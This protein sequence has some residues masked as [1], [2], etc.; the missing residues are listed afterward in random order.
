MATAIGVV[1]LCASSALPQGDVA[2]KEITL[3]IRF[4][5]MRGVSMEV[6]GRKMDV[7]VKPE[8]VR[9]VLIEVGKRYS[10]G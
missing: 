3:P 8:E 2:R 9:D 6:K 5:L 10:D 7:W 1:V 4:H